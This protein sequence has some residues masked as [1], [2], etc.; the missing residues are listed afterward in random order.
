MKTFQPDYQNIQ[1]AAFNRTAKRL[2]LYEH[3]VSFEKIEEITGHPLVALAQ[4]DD[5]DLLEFFHYYCNFFRDYGYDAVPFELC[6]G[7]AMPGSGALGNPQLEPVIKDRQDFEH[8]PWAEIPDLYFHRNSKV[9][10]ALGQKLPEGMKAIGGVGNGAFECVQDLVGYQNLCYLMADDPELVEEL[11]QKVG[12]VSLAIWQRFLKEQGEH[13]C[14][15]RFGDDLGFKSAPLLSKEMIQT[16]IIPQYVPIIAEVHKYKKPFLLHSCGCIFDV[17]EELIAAGIDAK[18]SN[19]DQIA[20]FPV[21]VEKYGDRIGNF[22]GIDT[23]MLCHGSKAELREYITEVL[24]KSQGHGGLAWGSG[25]S[26][27]KYVPA[28]GYLNMIEIVR[29]L[30]GDFSTVKNG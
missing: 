8:Y 10:S 13:Y 25:N 27:P 5:K 14:V 12:E 9:F 19:E 17:M 11:F 29:E 24:A 3:N 18:H 2:P 7:Q 30:R 6:I 20:P 28:E 16:L 15:L 26:I 4:G 22:G 21:W 1:D 23:D